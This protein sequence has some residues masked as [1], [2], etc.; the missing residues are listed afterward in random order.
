MPARRLCDT[1]H[2]TFWYF[3][4]GFYDCLLVINGPNWIVQLIYTS[5]SSLSSFAKHEAYDW[6]LLSSRLHV[7]PSVSLVGYFVFWMVER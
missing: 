3:P 6:Q 7:L 4:F 1:P 5:S 2:E